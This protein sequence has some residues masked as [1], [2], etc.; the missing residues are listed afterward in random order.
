MAVYFVK[1]KNKN[2]KLVDCINEEYGYE[3]KPNIKKDNLIQIS[4]LYVLD[5]RL[6]NQILTKKIEKSFRRL[7]AITLSVIN[8]ED[9][10]TGDAIIALDEIAKQKSIIIKKYREYLKEEQEEKILKRLKLL[11]K[12]LKEKLIMLQN[13][14]KRYTR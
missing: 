5:E 1:R 9:S 4:H 7:A 6:I 2:K 10:T 14:E 13:E 8:D 11:E 3:F 12:E